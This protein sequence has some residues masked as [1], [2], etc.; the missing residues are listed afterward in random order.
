MKNVSYLIIAFSAISYMKLDAMI[1]YSSNLNSHVNLNSNLTHQ[2]R[3]RD[4][5]QGTTQAE[6]LV[7]SGLTYKQACWVIHEQSLCPDLTPEQREYCMN[8]YD[9]QNN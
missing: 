8:L 4:M 9:Q 3:L 1:H 7:A 2:P 6:H 5:F